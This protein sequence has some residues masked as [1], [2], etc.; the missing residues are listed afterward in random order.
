MQSP[1]G[2]LGSREKADSHARGFLYAAGDGESYVLSYPAGKIVGT[3]DVGA[4]G[5][6]ADPRGNVYLTESESLA[7]Y[8]NGGTKPIS[9]I[10]VPGESVGCS[11]DSLTGNIA[12][13]YANNS[14][15]D[16]SVFPSGGSASTYEVALDVLYCG[17]DGQ[18]DLFVDG[19]GKQRFD[20]EE[21]PYG[22]SAFASVS[23]SPGISQNP[24]QVQYDGTYITVE[25]IASPPKNSGPV[26]YRLSVSGSAATVV[27][28]TTVSG[29]FGA[30]EQSWIDGSRMFIP[31][32]HGGSGEAETI[33]TWRYPAGGN[34]FKVVKHVTQKDGRL[35]GI[36]FGRAHN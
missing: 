34:A 25:G 10:S 12:V 2:A 27:G 4:L 19:I 15:S 13:T 31:Y 14:H 17:Y 7:E 11:V 29:S 33:G 32:A 5:A 1:I 21:L 16:V 24:G 36:A 18:G 28:K 20:L 23:I 22:G 26:I 6:C 3:I 35:N 30:S 9:T 8:S